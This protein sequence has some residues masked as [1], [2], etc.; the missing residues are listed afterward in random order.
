MIIAMARTPNASSGYT[1]AP[2]YLSAC[3]ATPISCITRFSLLTDARC[4][5]RVSWRLRARG[6]GKW[7]F[8]FYSAVYC[9]ARTVLIGKHADSGAVSYQV[10]AIGEI[11][12]RAAKFQHAAIVGYRHALGD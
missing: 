7:K 2:P 6:L 1:I 8:P 3:H 11:H 12:D 4:A 5:G 10:S 9:A